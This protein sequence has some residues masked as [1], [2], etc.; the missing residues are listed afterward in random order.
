MGRTIP[1]DHGGRGGPRCRAMNALDDVDVLLLDLNGTFMFGQDRFSAG[2][3]YAATARR[4]GAPAL[5]AGTINGL[6]QGCFD[7]V[8]RK[9]NDPAHVDDFPSVREILESIAPEGVTAAGLDALVEVFAEHELG[10]V[11]EEHAEAL[12]ALAGRYRLGL[13]SNLW[14]D[15]G[16]WVE[17]LERAGVLGLFETLVF[18]S[19][20]RSIKPSRVLF[21]LALESFPGVE[22]ERVAYVGDSLRCDVEGARGAGLRTVWITDGPGGPSPADVVVPSL[23]HLPAVVRCR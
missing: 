5:D 3:D 15:K 6:V 4:L 11:P 22:R 19:D 16:R 12:H 14:S 10:R 13:V 23:L 8:Q 2:E 18:S 1:L 20:T 17:E 7:V 21:D 9:Y